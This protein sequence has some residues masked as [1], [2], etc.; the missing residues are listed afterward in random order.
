MTST[1][2][3]GLGLP[4]DLD[5]GPTYSSGNPQTFGE[6]AIF[7]GGI[8]FGSVMFVDGTFQTNGS[9]SSIEVV[10]FLGGSG[11]DRLDV[12]GT[13]DPD[14]AVKL[15]GSVIV[16]PSAGGVDVTRSQP[17]DWKAQ[18]FLVGQPVHVSGLVGTWIVV[19]FSDSFDGDT[20]SN[21][22]MHLS[23]T[24]VAG[25][26]PSAT[27]TV[28]GVTTD[29]YAFGGALT[30]AAGSWVADG[31][32]LGQQVTIQG[33]PG[34]WQVVAISPDGKTLLLANGPGLADVAVAASVTLTRTTP[35]L[36]TLVADDVPVQA[37]VPITIV[38]GEFGGYV[39]RTDGGSWRD[40]GFQEG[41]LVRIQG[42]DGSW[43]VRRIEGAH[44]ETL[45]L[46]RGAVLP[47]IATPTTRL[48][49]WPGPHGGL[50]VVHGGGNTALRV[51]FELDSTG[52]TVTRLDGLSWI[53]AG[54]SLG[55]RVQI[56]G[57][58]ETRQ[59]I[60][61]SNAACP[62][63]DPF[64]G[65][66][67][68]STITLSA[69]THGDPVNVA[70]GLARGVH[71]AEPGKVTTTA[72]MNVTVQPTGPLGL[73]TSTLTCA[74]G[75]GNCF[76]AT[77]DGGAVFELGM[78]V[79]ISGLAGP[80]TVVGVSPTALVL[81]GAAL[82][83]TYSIVADALVWAPLTLAVSG[84]DVDYDGGTRM[85][86]DT[87]V[88]CNTGELVDPSKPCRGPNGTDALA[89]PG[90]PLVVYG[91]TSQDG[92]WYGGR[93]DDVKGYEFGPKPYDPFWKVPDA[94]NEDD[95]WIFPVAD[96][97]DFAG[98]DVVD[99]SGL[100]AW[101][102]CDATCSNLPTVGFTAYGGA[103]DDL[104]V[105]S[106][107]GDHLA[108][109]SGDDTILGLRGVD[110][111]YGDGGVNVDILTRGLT[112]PFANATPAPTLDPRNPGG[113]QTIAP[114]PMPNA[115][116][117]VAGHD[118]IHGEGSTTYVLGR[119][120]RIA[121]TTLGSP[122]V[123]Y[124]D[125]VFGDHG[126]V[127]QQ[128]ADGNQPDPRLQKIQTTSLASIRLIESR[129]YQNGG[130]D[131]I[132]G[133]L[134]R[135][136][137]V[138]GAGHDL[139]DGDEADDIVFGDNAFLLR[140][141]G[142]AE[143]PTSTDYAGPFDTT[144]PRFQALCGTL[145]YSRS[146]RPDACNGGTPAGSDTSGML[147]V[148]GVWLPYRDP[149]SPG[150]DAWP[151]WAE[152]L[153]DFDDE[154][155]S[156]Q[157]HG[158]D[159]QLSADDPTNPNARGAG[160]FGNDY[161][162]GGAAHD[163][164][165]GQMGDDVIQGDGGIEGAFA[166]TS[167]VGASRSPDGCAAVGGGIVCDYVGDLDLV[168]SFEAATDGEDYVE[169]GGGSDVVFGGLG[170]DDI[171]GGSSDFFGLAD[172]TLSL[173]GQS[174]AISGLTGTWTI[175]GVSG[176]TITLHGAALPAVQSTRTVEI[177]GA[178]KRL[179][180][181][182][183]T[184]TTTL[185]GGTLTIAGL[186]WASLGFVPGEDRRPDGSDLLFGGAGTQAGRNQDVAFAD[187]TAAANVHARDADTIVGD[188]GRIVRI[189][190]TN[191]TDL[192]PADADDQ[193]YVR[194]VYDDYS[195]ATGYDAN[196]KL[197]VRGVHLLDYTPGGPDFRPDVFFAP[198]TESPLCSSA[199]D[200]ATGE[201]STPLP[202]CEGNITTTTD[203]AD[204]TA[205]R[206][207]D[208]GGAD[209]V[210]GESSDDTVY[211]G[212]GNDVVYGDA[213]DDDLI[214]GWG[215]D[216]ISGGTGSDGVLGDDGRI[217]TSRNNATV[218]EPLYG[219]APLL[220][221]D[222]DDRESNGNV[223]NEFIY[224]PGQ[225]QTAT[226]NVAG[227]LKKA[228]DLTPYNLG[229]NDVAG[230][231]QIDVP[232]YDANNSDDVIFGGFDD[233]FLH[234]GSGDDAIGGGEALPD[235][236]V[237]HFTAGG[238]VNGVVR[239]D[240][241][242]PLN[243]GNLLLFGADFDPWLAP[244]PF[245]PRLGE[246]F[247]YDE[248][249]PRRA[250]VF[251]STGETWSCTA[252][253]PSGKT[254][255]ASP[256]LA[257]FPY[258]YFLNLLET[259]K[260][261]GGTVLPVTEGRETGLGCVST[262]PN[263]SCLLQATVNTDGDD[264]LYG[265]LGNDWLV[266][267]SGKD[268]LWGG[269]GN[270]LMNAD[271]ILTTNGS[272]ND[273]TD[274]HGSYEDRAYGGAGIDILIGNTGGDRLIDWVGEH[275]SYLVPFSPFGIATV[276]R[277]V[278]PWLPE[279]LYALSA[280]SGADPTRD[281]DTGRP[282]DRNG[283]FEGELGLIIQQD[284]GYWQQQ[285]GAPTD[286]Q[287][288]NIPGGKRDVLRGAD[289]N[290]G[291]MEGFATD[292][293]SF[294]VEGGALRV[295]AASQGRDA[296]AVFY[297]DQY[298]PIYF[299]IVA[300]VA[301]DKA[302]AGW[303]GNAYVIF[304]YFSP[305]DFKFVGINQKTNKVEMGQRTA[306]GWHVVTQSPLKIWENR[307]Y[308]LLVAINGTAV[309][310]VVDN[311]HAFTHV[312]AP[313]VIDGETYGLN[314]GMVGFGSQN[315]RGYFDNIT[316]QILPPQ[317]TLDYKEEFADGDV[318]PFTP[319][320]EG[321]WSVAGGR[322]TVAAPA[323]GTIS[324]S[325]FQ[326]GVQIRASSYLELTVGLRTAGIAGF[327]FDRYA[328]DDYK[329]VALD[330]TTGRVLIGHVSPRSGYR[331]DFAVAR[332][333]AAGADYT[334]QLVLKGTTLSVVV[335][336]QFVVS[337]AYNGIVVDGLFGLAAWSGTASFDNFRLRTDDPAWTTGPNGEPSTTLGGAPVAGS[338]GGGAGGGSSGATAAADGG[339]K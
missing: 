21:T 62:F 271:D 130:D 9:K 55:Q 155:L 211:A 320:P 277:Q 104:I 274:T 284:H 164:V 126:A 263:G 129:A 334:L 73:P 161:L 37:N 257:G 125:V 180:D 281:T 94:E 60:G 99:A 28:A 98:N 143:F 273:T 24:V 20:V 258:Q 192:A 34:V 245:A 305:T 282:A 32:A 298:L 52:T 209:E 112:I 101:I 154:D 287:P 35:L 237:Q 12:Q 162:A 229:P 318:H 251:D 302:Q 82:Q 181:A 48:V 259:T 256:P 264:V 163:L 63:D 214:G 336:G 333:L 145:L 44:G 176:A 311:K 105:G 83:P 222:P 182:L 268:E 38:G 107:A 49:Y 15:I 58:G 223:L 56:E 40:A 92:V 244:K 172:E 328:E 14:D 17:F 325:L 188:N 158:F 339:R 33:T 72:P 178:N 254:C 53:G 47:T 246:F 285:T 204:P 300:N 201:C 312:F 242:R 138:A 218:G 70:A 266:G 68:D 76:A 240:W 275:N 230:H 127:V 299:E 153:V 286:P 81:Q 80:W 248:Y 304:D 117:L 6:P 235:S 196:G 324:S 11:N 135:D 64:P 74:P 294:T 278:M 186:D 115:D 171:L 197:V 183:V 41:Q 91:D 102:T 270:D 19:G 131:A 106:Q 203:A 77:G 189:V 261:V 2:L 315:S 279:F 225:V 137:I 120:T 228:V 260:V 297:H 61:F 309:T 314:K 109:G 132:F 301:I 227:E 267:G 87:I 238:V 316:I 174:V 79:T 159:V 265:D 296:A 290:N 139:A 157:F 146:D 255:T 337:F 156:H 179:A 66:G 142:E 8:G 329:F 43:R 22:V 330:V 306:T 253:S 7:P 317:I 96:P 10:N 144:S 50:T 128:T 272:L 295:T 207:A 39:T 226:I 114:A 78:Q 85:G 140:R 150:L 210:H 213:Q 313:R 67:L 42:L 250:I 249:D 25:A 84:Y 54:F 262:A 5:F 243:P 177:V 191:G 30:R 307:N 65:C 13:I 175:T 331:V 88:V 289:F 236:Y 231:F 36:R 133:S 322:Y 110:H 288:G 16:T 121:A 233:D 151:W 170:Q 185:D 276:S 280:G 134:G 252:Y 51:E 190:G 23:G 216:W 165:F 149:D 206:Y 59:L 57:D 208:I 221:T 195:T 200:D 199:A 193:R 4:D 116:D 247:L 224:T 111:V 198:G 338:G 27:A 46:E 18:G 212:C 89:G 308:H 283:E 335:N 75:A 147:L 113:D 194:F 241:T 166:G 321:A 45:R 168:P 108:G 31:F 187:G 234:G 69:D 184:L 124:D 167:H 219:V 239:T 303:E 291:Q 160:S 86:G 232:L 173:V 326:V 122:Q 100:F 136:V 148:N 202:T 1:T 93:A 152:Y 141:V 95:E 123:A 292:S 169:G 29:G 119:T 323:P 205:S 269:W 103:G 26:Q 71:V 332:T 217:F 90:S 118:V 327:V 319:E 310:V 220:A 3:S 215:G 293:G 97:F